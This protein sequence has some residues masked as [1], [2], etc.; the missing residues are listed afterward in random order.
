MWVPVLVVVGSPVFGED[1]G[2][3][4]GVEELLVQEFVPDP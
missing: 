2:F 1:P 3:E 4:Q